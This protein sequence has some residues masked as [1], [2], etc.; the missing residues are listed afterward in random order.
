[1]SRLN[2]W[3]LPP[4]FFVAGGPWGRPAPGIPRALCLE[5]GRSN[6][7][8]RTQSAPRDR[9]NMPLAQLSSRPCAGTHSH[10]PTLPRRVSATRP[11]TETAVGVP[12]FAG[13][14]AKLE[15]SDEAAAVGANRVCRPDPARSRERQHATD[16]HSLP[17]AF[18]LNGS[19]APSS[20]PRIVP[21][22][23]RADISSSTPRRACRRPPRGSP[24]CSAARLA[25]RLRP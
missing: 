17:P 5:E 4:A 23:P 12:A 21:G 14:T 16:R 25:H 8:A 9:R 6:G 24:P 13:T 11:K 7:I 22:W 2:L 15:R 19:D 20:A 3:Y 10:R 18:G 1:M